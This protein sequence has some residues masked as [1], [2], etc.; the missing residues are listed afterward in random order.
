MS[1]ENKKKDF[2]SDLQEESLD[3]CLK[4]IKE[5]DSNQN[6]DIAPNTV[7][8][9]AI[10]IAGF[11]KKGQAGLIRSDEMC[12]KYNDIA[13]QFSEEGLKNPS[14]IFKMASE[15]SLETLADSNDTSKTRSV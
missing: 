12:K 7:K 13:A 9:A 15:Q 3:L 10:I 2:W 5:F 6:S 11:Y 4:I 1:K 14:P 8:E